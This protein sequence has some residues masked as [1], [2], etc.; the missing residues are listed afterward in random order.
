[1]R[2]DLYDTICRGVHDGPARLDMLGAER[3][4][5]LRARGMKITENAL[6]SSKLCDLCA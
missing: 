4:N 5:D 3:G 6:C 1:M 2:G